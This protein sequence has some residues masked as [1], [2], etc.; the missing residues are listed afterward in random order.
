MRKGIVIAP[1]LPEDY[2][3]LEH[4]VLVNEDFFV[5]LIK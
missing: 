5:Q 1:G 2:I 3:E 4:V